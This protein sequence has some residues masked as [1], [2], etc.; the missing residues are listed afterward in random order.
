MIIRTNVTRKNAKKIN[1]KQVEE[2]VIVKEEV[3]VM[4]NEI[5][6]KTKKK[7][8]IS[9]SIVVEEPVVVEEKVEDED[10]S[11]WLEE[12]IED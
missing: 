12:H 11:K 6:H 10:L 2:P 5:V 8:N 3:K 7:K 4:N 1:N 9:T